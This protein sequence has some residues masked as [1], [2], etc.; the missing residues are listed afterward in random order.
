MV[1][2]RNYAKW[3]QSDSETHHTLSLICGILKKDRMTFFTEQILTHRLC[4]TYGFQMRQFGGWDAL[5]IWG[6]NAIKLGCDDH[7]ATVN[8]I[9][10]HWVI[11]K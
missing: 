10:K 11:K 5:G 6:G 4:K 7:C 8:V 3:S 1:G 9:K 2:P